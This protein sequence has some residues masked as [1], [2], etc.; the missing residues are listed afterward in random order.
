MPARRAPRAADPQ[1]P[2]LAHAARLSRGRE[3]AELRLRAWAGS[4]PSEHALSNCATIGQAVL[5]GLRSLARPLSLEYE[6]PRVETSSP[7]R[8]AR[9][10]VVLGAVLQDTAI[11]GWV[12]HRLPRVMD[13][14]R[15]ARSAP[16]REAAAAASDGERQQHWSRVLEHVPFPDYSPTNGVS[17]DLGGGGACVYTFACTP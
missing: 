9:L 4:L 1:Q 16:E 12:D 5:A 13:P 6:L 14:A 17:C 10:Y 2:R 11:E 15:P 7:D 8:V 3:A